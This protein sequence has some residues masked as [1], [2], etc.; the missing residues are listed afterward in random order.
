MYEVV[1]HTVRHD[2]YLFGWVDVESV[3]EQT[4]FDESVV[5]SLLTAAVEAG[6]ITTGGM[7]LSGRQRYWDTDYSDGV[8]R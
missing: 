8:R 2:S 6:D 3:S 1:V 5:A 4:G 7:R